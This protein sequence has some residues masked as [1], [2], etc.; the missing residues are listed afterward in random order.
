[1]SEKNKELMDRIKS[2]FSGRERVH[3]YVDEWEQ[4]VYMSHLSLRE[5]DQIHKR[6]KDSP[7]QL[8]VYAL[9][10]KAEDAQGEKLFTLDDKVALLNNVSFQTVE[11][12]IAAMFSPEDVS[13]PE[14]N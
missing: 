14:K 12:I 13:N 3:F 5:Q 4:D 9:I 10:L 6:A 8:A 11:K 1:M 7:Y 2:H